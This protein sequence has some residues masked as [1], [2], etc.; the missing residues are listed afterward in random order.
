MAMCIHV[1]SAPQGTDTSVWLGLAKRLSAHWSLLLPPLLS[2]TGGSLSVVEE[3]PVKVVSLVQLIIK[4]IMSRVPWILNIG[5]AGSHL[6]TL[7]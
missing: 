4:A 2:S 1:C 7:F 5:A 6:P 3:G